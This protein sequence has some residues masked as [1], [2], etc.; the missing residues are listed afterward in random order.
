M[1]ARTLIVSAVCIAVAAIAMAQL[2]P[3]DQYYPQCSPNPPEEGDW[4]GGTA[5]TEIL[6]GPIQ[7]MF[8]ACTGKSNAS[9]CGG[10]PG[11]NCNTLNYYMS[12]AYIIRCGTGPQTFCISS[13]GAPA[14]MNRRCSDGE[15]CGPGEPVPFPT[16][17]YPPCENG[18]Q[19]K[20][21]MFPV[22]P[23]F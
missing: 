16:T 6:Q 18:Q 17:I 22:V 4:C 8:Y 9:D 20:P 3:C 15:P 1:I 12:E 14:P 19:C 21:V 7:F 13:I 11:S 2:Q 10:H 23:E 5:Q